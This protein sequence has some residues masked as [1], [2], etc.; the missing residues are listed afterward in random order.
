MESVLQ[1]GWNEKS[2]EEEEEEDR[3]EKKVSMTWGW[4]LTQ[5]SMSWS[6]SCDD[7]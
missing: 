7:S 4:S 3:R 5:W 6:I 1:R 2:E